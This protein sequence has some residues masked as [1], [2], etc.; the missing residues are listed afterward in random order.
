MNRNV[1]IA[2]A[3]AVLIA[4]GAVLAMQWSASQDEQPSASI[5]DAVEDMGDAV[6]EAGEDVNEAT[7]G[8]AEALED[9]AQEAEDA[10]DDP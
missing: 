5:E 6:E 10:T 3:V 2:L 7:G 1:M 8:A 4:I 9:A